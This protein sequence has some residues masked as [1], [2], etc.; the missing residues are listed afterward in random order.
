MS[1]S[2]AGSSGAL[3]R[4]ESALSAHTLAAHTLAARAEEHAKPTTP[5]G[6]R[7]QG[8]AGTQRK[9]RHVRCLP[10]RRA[11]ARQHF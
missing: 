5:A 8:A 9:D 4:T 7:L 6:R 10:D 2:S 1:A 11:E 3:H